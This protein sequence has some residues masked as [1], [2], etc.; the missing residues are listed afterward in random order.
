[1]NDK[2]LIVKYNGKYDT[3]D[4]YTNELTQYWLN[5]IQNENYVLYKW[6]REIKRYV[7]VR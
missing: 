6:D 5:K 3:E 2:Y 1:M 4:Y 7:E